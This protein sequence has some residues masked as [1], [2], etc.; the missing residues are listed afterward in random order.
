[1]GGRWQCCGFC[2]KISW[3]KMVH[4]CD[5]KTSSSGVKVW[6]EVFIHFHEIAVKIHTGMQNWLFGL[7]E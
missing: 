4:S 1:V 7:L 6:S 2:K 5:A 3:Q